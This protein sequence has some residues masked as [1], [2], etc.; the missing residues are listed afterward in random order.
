MDAVGYRNGL[1]WNEISRG[2]G[3][4]G[5][6]PLWYHDIGSLCRSARLVGLSHFVLEGVAHDSL[7]AVCN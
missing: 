3:L 7:A 4:F 5:F 2:F 6:Y 1:V